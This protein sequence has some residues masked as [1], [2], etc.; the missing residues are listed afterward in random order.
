M[1]RTRCGEQSLPRLL[2]NFNLS[3]CITC[4]HLSTSWYKACPVQSTV[5]GVSGAGVLLGGGGVEG[6]I[7]GGMVH[8]PP[9]VWDDRGRGVVREGR[10][11]GIPAG[12]QPRGRGGLADSEPRAAGWKDAAVV[13]CGGGTRGG[14]WG[15]FEGGDG[16]G[17]EGQG[18]GGGLKTLQMSRLFNPEALQPEILHP[19]PQTRRTSQGRLGLL[20]I[21]WVWNGMLRWK[22]AE[23]L[24]DTVSTV[25]V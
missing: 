9:R 18:E 1:R 10:A 6:C 22:V 23:E 20:C 14:C 17:G 13:G 25:P 5:V 8:A 3:S 7:G 11:I 24:L 4:P 2:T 12:Y 15:S 19:R 21:C 16:Q